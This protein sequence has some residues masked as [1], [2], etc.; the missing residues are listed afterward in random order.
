MEVAVWLTAVCLSEIK[1]VQTARENFRRR[2]PRR[3]KVAR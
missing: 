2:R 1:L 3:V